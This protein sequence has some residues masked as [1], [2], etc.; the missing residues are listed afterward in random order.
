[1][2]TQY[3][4]SYQGRNSSPKVRLSKSFAE[5]KAIV[6]C[7]PSGYGAVESDGNCAV[8]IRSGRKER[9]NETDEELQNS[10]TLVLTPSATQLPVASGKPMLVQEHQ[11]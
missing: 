8:G 6:R 7:R 10:K 1:M 4:R 9:K 11:L 5:K 3:T 2:L